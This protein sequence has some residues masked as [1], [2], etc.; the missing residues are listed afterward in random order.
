M[1]AGFG[2][3]VCRDIDDRGIRGCRG[4]DGEFRPAVTALGGGL[5]GGKFALDLGPK[6]QLG[7][8]F[9]FAIFE[10]DCAPAFD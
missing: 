3:G 8:V 5:E 4:F 7:F 6:T 10:Q 1:G 9:V 2:R